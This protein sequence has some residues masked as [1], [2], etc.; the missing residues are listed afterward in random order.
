[1]D[2]SSRTHQPGGRQ[3]SEDH[4]PLLEPTQEKEEDMATGS[5]AMGIYA[6]YLKYFG[7]WRFALLCLFLFGAR[8]SAG[9]FQQAWLAECEYDFSAWI[10]AGIR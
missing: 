4:E 8:T 5:V 2:R 6:V 1:M 3:N 10:D 7:G 9:V